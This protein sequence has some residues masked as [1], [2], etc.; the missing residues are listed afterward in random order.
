MPL[1]KLS[2]VLHFPILPSFYL[3]TLH[4]FFLAFLSSVQ[5]NQNSEQGNEGNIL[6]NKEE[7]MGW[8]KM[9][10]ENL[11]NLYYTPNITTVMKIWMIGWRG[12]AACIGN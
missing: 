4:I 9:H 12:H 8:R 11:N 2:Y 6:P 5:L 7:A 3:L 1:M 10:N